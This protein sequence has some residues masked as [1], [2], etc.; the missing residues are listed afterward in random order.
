MESMLLVFLIF[1]VAFISLM[2]LRWP[3]A[4]ALASASILA[5][6]FVAGGGTLGNFAVLSYNAMFSYNMLALPFFIL[7]GEILIVGGIAG[8]LYDSVVPLMERLPG[9]LIHT[10]I[11]ANVILGACSGS[12]IA[13]T[14]A[15]S[16]V[17]IPELSKRGYDKSICYGS[18]ASAG[19]LACMIP[20][21][22]GLIIFAS[23]TTVSLGQLFIA[24]IVP[25]LLQAASFSLVVAIWVKLKPNATPSVAKSCMPFGRAV[26]F[27]LK[28]LWPLFF[29]IIMVL[30]VIYLGI[31]TP[32][33]SGCAGVIGA[34][35]LCYKNLNRKVLFKSL[36]NTC[37]I[38]GALLFIIAMASVY[39]FA[40]NALGLREY[41]LS[42][43]A[44]LPGGPIIQMY[45]VW[46]M[47]LLLGMFL[48]SASVIV[49]ATPILLP[50]AVNL[51]YEPLWFG[52]FL[53]LAVE[54]GN[55]TPPVGLTLFAVQVIGKSPMNIV[56]RGALPFWLSFLLV[57]SLF[58]AFP[59][60]VT[61]LPNLSM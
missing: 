14:T 45:M 27:A 12:T 55:I 1:V 42:L 28:N 35:V 24:G 32:T 41:I 17:A 61:W 2:L 16:S 34:L 48:D 15:I 22:I 9:G 40:L 52:I 6:V 5:Y 26:F 7:M 8:K 60:M 31:G 29:L 56:A 43:L 13:A 4:F 38:S 36:L 47:L 20:P 37:Q 39:G 23:V 54:L 59:A 49:I 50:F 53:M 58:I 18:L 51:G 21:S 44:V 10:N 46:I 19:C 11:F 57:T 33:E 25:G 3:I 30:G